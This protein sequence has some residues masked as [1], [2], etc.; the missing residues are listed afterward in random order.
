VTEY[1]FGLVLEKESKRSLDVHLLRFGVV[2][3]FVEDCS[4]LA[5]LVVGISVEVVDIMVAVAGCFF[6]VEIDFLLVN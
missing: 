1:S 5:D 4:K 2:V 6:V 3:V